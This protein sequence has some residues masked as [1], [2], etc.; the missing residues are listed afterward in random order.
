MPDK[1]RVPTEQGAD[2]SVQAFL[3]KVASTPSVKAS[4]E[5][6]RLLF[7][8][9]AT[10]SRQPTWDRAAQIQGEMFQETASLGGLELQLCFYQGF[11]EFK[12]SPWMTDSAALTRMMTAVSCLAG[13]TQIRKVLR[14]AVNETRRQ[15]VHALVF[16]G[17]CMEEDVDRLGAEAGEL[18][19]LGVP[20]FMFH[21]GNDPAAAFAFEQVA[22]L[23]GGACCRF[24]ASS[25]N[26][27]RDLLRAVA[28]YAA[29]GK[30]A[31]DALADRTG[32]D[33]LRI[34]H[35]VKGR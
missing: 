10:A 28:V 20:A 13:Q 30:K 6:G 11:G 16:V 7:A 29:G 22:R 1:T 35:Q 12:V 24:D 21:E 26:V 27:L 5:R 32:G 19:V 9:D 8:L 23:T 25:P 14:H 2:R 17:D 3:D 4:G 18:G 34:A 33:V 31:L 15:R